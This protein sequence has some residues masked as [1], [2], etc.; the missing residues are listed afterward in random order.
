MVRPLLLVL[1]LTLAALVS[2]NLLTSLPGWAPP[3][4]AP[5][6]SRTR[7]FRVLVPAH[8]E[9]KVI[10]AIGADLRG[11]E[12]PPELVRAVV[13]ADRCRDGT[14]P[15][16]RQ[17]GMAVVER[18]EGPDGK[19]A[20][21]SWYLAADPLAPG[22][23]LVILDADNRVGPDLLGRYAD[24]LDAG[25]T[26][27]QAYLDVANPD[28]SLIASLS[29]LSYWA[30]N[31]MVQQ[32]RRRLGWT[33]DLGGTGMCFTGQ[34]LAAA[35]GFGDSLVEDQDL[36]A[37]LLLAG[38]RVR[39]L[40]L[41]RI[42]DEKPASVTVAV[43]QR[44]RWI[45]GRR[46]LARRM[47]PRLLAAGSPESWDLAIRMVQPSR[48]GVAGF[49]VC[50]AILSALGLPLW[51]WPVWAGLALLQLAVPLAFLVR[52]EVPARYLVR[53]PLLVLLPL[54]KLGARLARQRG[55]YHTPHGPS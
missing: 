43:R 34:A 31:R 7:R 42:R 49:S 5:P 9:E 11:Q 25:A 45:R 3:R 4:L 28:D 2:Y 33:A 52:E 1:E 20:A 39:W 55:W 40:H 35:G 44:G 12:Y 30:S 27:L 26:V 37:R 24:E 23:D 13:L 29:A 17:A 53:Y 54:L 15:L 21:I 6:G 10:S 46:R 48:I 47:A 50:L 51:P 19:G 18:E 41:V 16:A 36:G 32:A 38:H 8:D 22:E 14:A